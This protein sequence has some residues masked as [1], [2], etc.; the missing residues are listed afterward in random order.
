MAQKDKYNSL[1]EL[2][3]KTLGGTVLEEPSFIG[4]I[5]L[6]GN[7]TRHFLVLKTSIRHP[8]VARFGQRRIGRR[9]FE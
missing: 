5:V 9:H 1:D 4:K 7:T 8:C 6:P 3:G 2:K